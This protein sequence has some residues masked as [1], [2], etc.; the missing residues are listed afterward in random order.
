[1]GTRANH[2]YIGQN[3]NDVL[4]NFANGITDEEINNLPDVVI[5]YSHWDG[6]PE[7]IGQEIVDILEKHQGIRQYDNE[8][9]GAR[10]LQHLMGCP[11]EGNYLS[12]GICNQIH[13]DIAYLYVIDNGGV[14][15]FKANGYDSKSYSFIK[16][17]N[18]R[19]N[20]NNHY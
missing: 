20:T 1:M 5:T 6:Y 19:S 16:Y 17:V 8:Y 15:M 12:F 18:T 4:P 9:C 3:I 7:N 13:G 10:V 11:Q 14:A 2:I